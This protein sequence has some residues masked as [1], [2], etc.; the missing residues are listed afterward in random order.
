ML[1][2]NLNVS[3]NPYGRQPKCPIPEHPLRETYQ[4]GIA[5]IEL[6]IDMHERNATCRQQN[7]GKDLLNLW[8]HVTLMDASWGVSAT[9]G[10]IKLATRNISL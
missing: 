1:F 4:S 9:K 8:V 7:Q 10:V 2:C 5:S 6:M 3:I